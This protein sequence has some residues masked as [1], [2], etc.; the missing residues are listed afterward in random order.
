MKL[1]NYWNQFEFEFEFKFDAQV[2][3][4][5]IKYSNGQD[6][7]VTRDTINIL[8]L[9]CMYIHKYNVWRWR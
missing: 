5:E 1:N 7:Q 2:E 4:R 6:D 3:T 9:F 8:Q